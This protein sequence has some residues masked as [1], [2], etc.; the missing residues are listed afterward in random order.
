MKPMNEELST[1]II[2]VVEII[3]EGN[4]TQFDT[5]LLKPTKPCKVQVEFLSIASY[6][7]NTAWGFQIYDDGDTQRY[8]T[9]TG[10]KPGGASASSNISAAVPYWL[11]F[12]ADPPTWGEMAPYGVL[13]PGW[14]FRFR[15]EIGAGAGYKMWMRATAFEMGVMR[16]SDVA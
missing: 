10:V 13:L 11:T 4:G 15:S 16:Q 5:L 2:E 9:N 8:T 1:N 12:Q 6:G 7:S 14:E 3:V